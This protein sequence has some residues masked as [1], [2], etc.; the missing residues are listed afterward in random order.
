MN[1]IGFPPDIQGI[2][3]DYLCDTECYKEIFKKVLK[4]FNDRNWVSEAKDL[5]IRGLYIPPGTRFGDSRFWHR[6]TL[7]WYEGNN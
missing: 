3:G 1:K 2:I 7:F 6:D 5:E 4:V